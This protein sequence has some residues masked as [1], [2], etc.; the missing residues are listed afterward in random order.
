[1]I[2]KH[3]HLQTTPLSEHQCI[4]QRKQNGFEGE[5]GAQR[6]IHLIPLTTTLPQN[7]TGELLEET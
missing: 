7:A 3:I 4:E 5:F 2:E 6:S 1:M